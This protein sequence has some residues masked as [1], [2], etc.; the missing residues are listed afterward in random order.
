M[1]QTCQRAARDGKDYEH[2]F[3]VM[4]PDGSL[5]HIHIVAHSSRDTLGNLGEGMFGAVMDVTCPKQCCG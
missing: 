3:R 1:E 5:K 4:M 2:K